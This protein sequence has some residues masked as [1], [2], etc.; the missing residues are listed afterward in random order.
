MFFEMK[1][2]L[3]LMHIHCILRRY[4]FSSDHSRWNCGD[5]SDSKSCGKEKGGEW[6]GKAGGRRARIRLRATGFTVY[7]VKPVACQ[8]APR[9]KTIRKPAAPDGRGYSFPCRCGRWPRFPKGGTRRPGA[10]ELR[11]VP[12][13]PA[14][15]GGILPPA[16]S[17]AVSL[18][19]PTLEIDLA[20]GVP[21]SV[22]LLDF[23]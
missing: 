23:Q 18:P 6:I 1:R 3:K 21:Y 15:P 22:P 8:T 4:I 9:F 11:S 5:Y 19:F 13:R 14:P 2:D 20:G 17:R 12:G 16:Q 7:T 10:F